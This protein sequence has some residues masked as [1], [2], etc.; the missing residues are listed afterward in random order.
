MDLT[1]GDVAR[2]INYSPET[3]RKIEAGALKPSKQIAAL[4]AGA[5]E[6][7]DE[8]HDAFGAFAVGGGKR[9]P[10]RI[11]NLPKPLTELIGRSEDLGALQKLLKRPETRLLTLVGP[12]G[13]GKTRLAVELTRQAAEQFADGAYFVELAALTSPQVVQAI[14]AT[15]LGVEERADQPMLT[16]MQSHLPATDLPCCKRY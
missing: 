15:T 11:N 4:L 13:V 10:V 3:V 8:R 12:G 16:S 2:R 14:V 5:L 9:G 7:P 1:Q 6:I